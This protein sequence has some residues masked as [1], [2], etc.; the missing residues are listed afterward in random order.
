MSSTPIPL[1]IAIAAS[2]TQ[3]TF[4]P[5]KSAGSSTTPAMGA[6]GRLRLADR[7]VIMEKL[8][9]V[10]ATSASVTT[11]ERPPIGTRI[12]IESVPAEIVR[13]TCDGFAVRFL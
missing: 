13:H 11:Q 12:W 1:Q 6:K 7:R 3:Q 2:L 9:D 10:S 5:Q 8:Q 4:Q